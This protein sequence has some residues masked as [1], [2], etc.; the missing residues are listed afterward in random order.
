M[1]EYWAIIL[2]LVAAFLGSFG[3]L[4][5][6]MGANKLELSI[7]GLLKNY[8]LIKGLFIYGASTI[9]YVIAI[10]GGELSV[11]FPL[12]STG[13][14]W[15]VILSMKYLDEKMNTMK[16]MGMGAIILGVILIGLGS[17]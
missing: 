12:V 6:K 14:I 7:D 2:V 15:V 16:I 8:V 11:L 10:K 5:F 9:I 17:Q 4:C 1:T 3:S 13:Y